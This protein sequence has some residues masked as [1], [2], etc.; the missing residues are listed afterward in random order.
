MP[1]IPYGGLVILVAIVLGFTGI[2]YFPISPFFRSG[3]P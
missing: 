2:P 1:R 3:W